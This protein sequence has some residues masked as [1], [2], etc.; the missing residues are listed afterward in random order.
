MTA[1]RDDHDHERRPQV[2]DAPQVPLP[3][4][5]EEREREP[6][7]RDPHVRDGVVGGVAL[8]AH[9]LDDL[10]RER[11]HAGGD[12]EAEAERQPERLRA[13]AVRDLR[14]PRSRRAPDLRRRPVLEEVEDRR[15]GR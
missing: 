15:R 12:R 10:R 14:L 11:D 3:A 4:E 2:G 5:R 6:E 9:Q 13:E 1:L 7:R 8:D